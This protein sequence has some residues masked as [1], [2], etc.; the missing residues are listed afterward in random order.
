MS[1]P[2][3]GLIRL[4]AEGL[5]VERS[6]PP[7]E[8]GAQSAEASVVDALRAQDEAVRTFLQF[9]PIAGTHSQRFENPC[10]KRHL[11]LGCDLDE[12]DGHVLLTYYL[13]RFP[14]ALISTVPPRARSRCIGGNLAARHRT[15]EQHRL[16]PAPAGHAILLSNLSVRYLMRLLT[17]SAEH[18][19]S[20]REQTIELDGFSLFIGSNAAGKSTVLDALRFLSEA[21]RA[22]DFTEPLFTRGGMNHLAWKGEPAQQIGLTVRVENGGR[23]F[24]WAVR[25]ARAGHDVAAD[26]HVDELSAQAPPT[27][28]L[29]SSG[30]RGW[31]WS[32]K[33]GRVELK[34]SAA[35]CALASAAADATFPARD[36]AGFIGRWGFFDPNPFL[37]RRDW[38]GVDSARF[39]HYGRNLGATLHALQRS[40]PDALKRIVDA[41][42]AI[43]GLPS[44]IE[45]RESED[46]FYFVQREPGLQYTVH[47]MGVSSGT[48]RMLALMTALY[49]ETETNLIGIE[50]PENYVHPTALSS[51]LQHL[52]GAQDRIQF[53]VTTHSPLLLDYLNDPEAVRI[54]RRD[55]RRG[56]SILREGDPDG[57]RKALDASGF[58]LG[59]FYETKG[60]GSDSTWPGAS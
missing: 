52:Q 31:W 42:R 57:V 3:R 39:D 43:L 46:R 45:P 11:T 59:E 20:L 9:D 34:Q 41:T 1:I 47:Q 36:V 6:V 32:G 19:R 28:L 5:D 15:G 24:E 27:R 54:V 51:F 37:L 49:A 56:T 58:G 25:L 55:S 53:L 8:L 10:G 14:V 4:I 44:D 33:E 38:T 21:V 13:M 35:A 18:Y 40:D 48:L 29:D 16:L 60:F 23:R 2:K 12:H 50:E 7:L 17:L 22:R 30:G 26:E